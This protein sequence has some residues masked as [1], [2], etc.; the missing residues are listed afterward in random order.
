[1]TPIDLISELAVRVKDITKDY[2]LMESDNPTKFRAP[3]VFLQ[4]LPEKEN[5]GD[6]DPADLPFILVALGGGIVNA[7]DQPPPIG[8]C[9]VAIW[10]AAYDEGLPL[11]GEGNPVWCKRNTEGVLVGKDG[12][13]VEGVRD[14][15]GWMAVSDMVWRIVTELVKDPIVATFRLEYPVYWE[16]PVEWDPVLHWHGIIN[17][18]W[19]VPVPERQLDLENDSFS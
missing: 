8:T 7:P 5:E 4:H 13:P 2:R 12:E 17:T 15:Q 16:V 10:C 18:T 9:S 14:Q 3:R 1:M 19:T 6:E 11:D